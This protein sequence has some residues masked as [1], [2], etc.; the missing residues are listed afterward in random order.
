MSDQGDNERADIEEGELDG[1]VAGAR[2]DDNDEIEEIDLDEGE[3]FADVAM[4]LAVMMDADERSVDECESVDGSEN[5][6]KPAEEERNEDETFDKTLPSTH[7]YLGETQE[8]SGRTLVDEND[9]VSMPLLLH[10]SLMN[11]VLV[12]GQRLPLTVFHPM[13]I[14]ML[15]S[16]IAKDHT[17]GIVHTNSGSEMARYGTTAE[18]YE[19]QEDE[20][21]GA[22]SI[23]AKGRQRF[24]ILNTRQ[25]TSGCVVAR[26]QILPEVQMPD[27]L[28]YVQLPSLDRVNIPSTEPEGAQAIS[29]Q[30]SVLSRSRKQV[31]VRRRNAFLTVWPPWVYDLYDAEILARRVRAE[32]YA[33]TMPHAGHLAIPE[34]PLELSNWAST[35]LLLEDSHRLNLLS[36]HTPTQRLRF[37]LSVISKC[38]L[39]TCIRCGKGIA[40]TSDIFS[41]SVEG[42]QGTYVNPGGYV[43]EM[44]TLSKIS[45]LSYYEG[46]ST[47]HSWFPGYAWTIANCSGCDSHMGWKF[48]AVKR[49]LKPQKFYGI[50]R[51]SV[52]A[53]LI[54]DDAEGEEKHVI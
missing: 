19:F 24:R 29:L 52:C 44:I 12:P 17:F 50:S 39:L 38:K 35:N 18:I 28:Q 15:K 6:D 21:T 34:D 4:G 22:L 16:I 36:L 20:M 45:G 53:K 13:H 47:E 9:Y 27:P 49:K 48:T 14:S 54:V 46:P 2:E 7:A 37:I 43:H 51:K 42:F 26:V 25:E 40:S 23:K 11:L 3:F 1:A 5:G 8:L 30:Q 31:G 41:M 32:I 33:S 10:N